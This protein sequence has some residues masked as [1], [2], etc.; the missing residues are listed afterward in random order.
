MQS[1]LPVLP[2]EGVGSHRTGSLSTFHIFGGSL[3]RSLKQITAFRR[4][5]AGSLYLHLYKV[6]VAQ[7]HAKASCHSM[8]LQM[9]RFR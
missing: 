2:P 7:S 9:N 8:Y 1:S 3:H 4:T 6:S 5:G